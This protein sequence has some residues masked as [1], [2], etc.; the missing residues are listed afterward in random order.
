M[1]IKMLK[2]Y[3]LI[4]YSLLDNTPRM[5]YLVVFLH[6]E[7]NVFK[8][9]RTCKKLLVH[10]VILNNLLHSCRIY[11]TVLSFYHNTVLIERMYLYL[12]E[13]FAF[14]YSLSSSFPLQFYLSS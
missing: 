14:L 10:S 4:Y 9:N 2:N 12:F 5:F 6:E 3:R 13:F 1:I 11:N 8:N 7:I